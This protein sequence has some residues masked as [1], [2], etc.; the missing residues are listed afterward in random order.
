MLAGGTCLLGERMSVQAPGSKGGGL[1]SALTGRH[2]DVWHLVAG[3]AGGA[4]ST[5]V[6]FPLDLI[7]TRFQVHNGHLEGD[8]FLRIP[9][10]RG[11]LDAARRIFHTEGFR[12]FYQGLSPALLGASASWGL[13]FFFYENAKARRQ[14]QAGVASAGHSRLP[15]SE[16]L[17]SAC[18]AGVVTTLCTNPIWLVKTRLQLQVRTDSMPDAR[19]LTQNYRGFWGVCA[20]RPAAPRCRPVTAQCPAPCPAQ[21][22]WSPWCALRARWPCTAASF[23]PSSS[24]PTEPSSS[25][26][27][28]SSSAASAW[29]GTTRCERRRLPVMPPHTHTHTHTSSS[30]PQRAHHTLAMA[31][32]SKLVA[33]T[34]TYPYQV[35]KSRLQARGAEAR[36]NGFLDCVA[37]TWRGEGVQGFFRGL[38]PNVARVVPSSAITFLAYETIMQGVRRAA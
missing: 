34:V 7:K 3:T 36:Y 24:S 13:Y 21:T 4:V 12:G 6:L 30:S 33:S 10:Y 2:L 17:L 31:S 38:T 8:R 1:S 26:S 11:M 15:T 19:Q 29:R 5:A 18:E 16:H 20:P 14:H 27:T 32:A 22:P 9:R 28:R 25:R 23:P 37:R 35:V